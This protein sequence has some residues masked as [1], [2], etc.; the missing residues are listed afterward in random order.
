MMEYLFDLVF[1]GISNINA[2]L[3][4]ASSML[5]SHI[6]FFYFQTLSASYR[7][8]YLALLQCSDIIVAPLIF[9]ANDIKFPL[10]LCD[11]SVWVCSP[12]VFEQTTA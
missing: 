3:P 12:W 2:K 9:M 8:T 10:Y 4:T 11:K 6:Q 1:V 5:L 7:S